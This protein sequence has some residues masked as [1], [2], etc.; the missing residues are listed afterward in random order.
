MVRGHQLRK[1]SALSP[2][3]PLL[4]GYVRPIELLRII[5]GMVKW[6]RTIK[7]LSLSD[8]SEWEKLD[9]QS[10]SEFFKEEFGVNFLEYFIEPLLQGF[11]Y[12][13]P[14]ESSKALGMMLLC[15]F[16]QKGR[17]MTLSKGIG[18]LPE[19]LASMLD[20][21][22][23]CPVTSLD[24]DSIGV[25]VRFNGETRHYDY[26]I[27]AATASVAKS[28]LKG[29]T[30]IEEKLISTKYSSTI[31]IAVA[32]KTNWRSDSLLR[33]IYGIMIP[34][35]EREHLASI[36]IESQK[37][38]ERVTGRGEL[39]DLMLDSKSARLFLS[40]DNDT[41]LSAI[42]PESE[43]YFAGLSEA[44]RFSHIIR[45]SEAEPMS[46]I[47][48]SKDLATYRKELP[49]TRRILLAGDYMG[50]PYTDSAAY[51][52]KWAAQKI[53]NDILFRA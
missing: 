9:N 23:N 50:F 5:F 34:R 38:I 46:P 29:A 41:I 47:G 21:R 13:S 44:I 37:D 43:H 22:L 32:T 33:N 42:L 18:S 39:L 35:R 10:A 53:S 49:A 19:K 52:G 31:N 27:L 24:Q 30:P 6:G 15:F 12:Q 3:S 26:V 28:L 4:S 51:T 14:E 2:L 48:R 36:G 11:Y 25:N 17:V 45:W 20:V 1:M 8:Y 7:D 40:E 16:L